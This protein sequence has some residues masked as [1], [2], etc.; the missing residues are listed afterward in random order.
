MNI[1]RFT[2]KSIEA[3]NTCEKLALEYGNHLS[4]EVHILK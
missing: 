2:Q 4:F 1:Q 3:V